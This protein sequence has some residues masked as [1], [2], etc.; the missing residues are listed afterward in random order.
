MEGDGLLRRCVIHVLFPCQIVVTLLLC[1]R[2]W[3]MVLPVLQMA[4]EGTL[5]DLTF[6]TVFEVSSRTRHG[7]FLV[8]P[9]VSVCHCSTNSMTETFRGW[10]YPYVQNLSHSGTLYISKACCSPR[11]TTAV[12][13]GRQQSQGVHLQPS[14]NGSTNLLNFLHYY[15]RKSEQREM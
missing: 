14:M 5:S 10:S 4:R 6:R 9:R 15:Y 8:R 3:L 13:M 1:L 11:Q 2:D 12:S 7:G